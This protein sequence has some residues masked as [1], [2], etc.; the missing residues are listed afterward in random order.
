MTPLFWM[1]LTWVLC[2]TAVE[3]LP[4]AQ[5]PLP[6][7]LLLLAAVPILL[8]IILQMGF[9][10]GILAL[11]GVLLMFPNPVRLVLAYYRGER[12]AIDANVLR[13]L[14]VPGEL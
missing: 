13:Y 9:L 3:R 1:A 4:V 11:A 7:A 10:A 2:A 6:G 12:F 8:M 14:A 5:R